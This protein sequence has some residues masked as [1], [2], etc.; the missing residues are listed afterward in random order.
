MHARGLNIWFAVQ[1]NEWQAYW[2]L[3]FD[4]TFKQ[5]SN[6]FYDLEANE[7]LSSQYLKT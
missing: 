6:V 4:C 7:Q 1:D 2:L 3:Y 5:E